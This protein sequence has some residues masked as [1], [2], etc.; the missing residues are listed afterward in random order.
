MKIHEYQAKEI[1]AR[2][3]IPVNSGELA[4]TPDEAE[5]IARKI[6]K[7]VVVKAQVL[8]GGR[9][10]AG[11]VKLA[12]TP[13][14]A[15]EKAQQ[16]LG[17]DIKGITVQKV[18][19]ADA[20]DIAQ[21]YYLGAILDRGSKQ[22][23]VMASAAGGVEIEEVA[24]E[25]PELIH[26]VGVDPLIGFQDFQARDLA[27][28]M[29]IPAPLIRDF[30]KICRGLVDALI[31]GDASLAEIN[32]LIRTPDGK[33]LAIDA[34]MD[35]DDFGLARHPDLEAL[36]D[37]NEDIPVE[38]A[39][40]EAGLSY[41]KLDG[42]IGCMVNGSGL[43]MGTMDAI[44]LHGGEP[45]NF[46]DVSGGANEQQVTTAM[47]L[48]LSDPKV[49]AVLINIFGGITRGD[50]V[51][52]GILAGLKAVQTD[53]PM[54]IRLVGTNSEEGRQILADNGLVALESMDEAAAK[55]VALAHERAAQG[56]T[57]KEAHA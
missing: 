54:V 5:A 28:A 30:V 48:I 8:V 29:E 42:D 17:M 14:E 55:V 31:A 45:A 2:H 15:R 26:R 6:G 3:G 33:L 46:L 49:N 47:R 19:I 36:R 18:L 38:K 10:K 53:L 41:V 11:G 44:K 51:A 34:K 7:M 16:I 21:E 22:I 57:Q 12:K 32:P 24:R 43:A 39:A 25:T 20:A 37:P 27:Y 50:I 52:R 4:T 23:V 1:L 35:L 40:R 9:G 56:Q 13:E